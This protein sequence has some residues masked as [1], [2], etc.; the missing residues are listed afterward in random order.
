MTYEVVKSNFNDQG[1]HGYAPRA[2]DTIVVVISFIDRLM[3]SMSW[4]NDQW[5]FAPIAKSNRKGFYADKFTIDVDR[6]RIDCA[7]ALKMDRG[8]D[9]SLPVSIG[10]MVDAHGA[11]T[12]TASIKFGES[13]CVV[14]MTKEASVNSA[15]AEACAAI[16]A[17]VLKAADAKASTA[18]D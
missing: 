12:H 4:P 17:Y 1:G 18:F 6:R 5:S 11:P 15:L 16:T 3:A 13:Q 8:E 14:E 7:L 10:L 9:V 2:Q